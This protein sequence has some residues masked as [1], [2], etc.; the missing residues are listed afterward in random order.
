[1][2]KCE[3]FTA[4]HCNNHT[5]ISQNT[6]CRMTTIRQSLRLLFVYNTKIP[7]AFISKKKTEPLYCILFKNLNI[8]GLSNANFKKT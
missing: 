2:N 4:V 7:L 8:H 5:A 3:V 1:M 6:D